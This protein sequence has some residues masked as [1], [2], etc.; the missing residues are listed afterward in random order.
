MLSQ[1]ADVIEL[2][3]YRDDLIKGMEAAQ[4]RS[5]E[6]R[7]SRREVHD[8]LRRYHDFVSLPDLHRHRADD[9]DDRCL[10]PIFG[11]ASSYRGDGSSRSKAGK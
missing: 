7:D 4:M 9:L 8:L 11:I 5:G 2:L 6:L 1:G 10:R 3:P